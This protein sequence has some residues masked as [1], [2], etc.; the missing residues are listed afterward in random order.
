LNGPLDAFP[1]LPALSVQLA[2]IVA[3][4]ASGPE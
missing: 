4:V 1:V 3:P 2:L